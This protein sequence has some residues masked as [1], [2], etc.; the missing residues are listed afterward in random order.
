ML[1]NNRELASLIWLAVAAAWILSRRNL[2][3]AT[4]D[5]LK[6]L[7][8]PLLLVP[9]LVMLGWVALEIWVGGKLALWNTGLV[10][11]TIVW[12]M[13]TALVLYFNI[14]KAAEDPLFFRNTSK[15]TLKAV[16][17]H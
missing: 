13:G 4:S 12:T 8:S 6:H 11:N 3:S 7:A 5:I 1:L 2:R 17:D 9:L 10:S 16:S 14:D 15:D